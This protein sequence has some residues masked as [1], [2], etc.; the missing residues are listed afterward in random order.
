MG[1]YTSH[2]VTYTAEKETSVNRRKCL[3]KFV[4]VLSPIEEQG[5]LRTGCPLFL[6]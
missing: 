3:T 6:L 2:A 5:T 1:K 4:N